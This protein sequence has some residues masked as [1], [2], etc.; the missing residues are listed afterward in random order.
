VPA[1]L[2]VFVTSKPTATLPDES[3]APTLRLL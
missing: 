1:R 3:G 2:P